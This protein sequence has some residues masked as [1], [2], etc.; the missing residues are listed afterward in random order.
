[1]NLYRNWNQFP[2]KG[3][4]VSFD[5]VK[6]M[7]EEG[8]RERIRRTFKDFLYFLV[9]VNPQTVDRIIKRE[10]IR[11]IIID[12]VKELRE[13]I[14]DD[15]FIIV[16]IA[17]LEVVISKNILDLNSIDD[18]IMNHLHLVKSKFFRDVVFEIYI[19][20]QESMSTFKTIIEILSSGRKSP[21]FGIPSFSLYSFKYGFGLDDF[22]EHFSHLMN[23]FQDRKVF[24]SIKYK[25]DVVF[26]LREMDS[27]AKRINELLKMRLPVLTEEDILLLDKNQ[28]DMKLDL[29]KKNLPDFMR[30]LNKVLNRSVSEDSVGYILKSFNNSQSTSNFEYV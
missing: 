28:T 20:S 29:S 27:F 6:D 12:C 25:S 14:E 22:E 17:G 21:F 26:Y 2:E 24:T 5:L 13:E 9:R 10:I 3:L 19:S 7:I 23:L 1:M 16:L 4:M 30:A 15:E 18:L 8:N 11:N